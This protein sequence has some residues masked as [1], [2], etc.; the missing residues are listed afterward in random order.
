[1]QHHDSTIQCKAGYLFVFCQTLEM[2]LKDRNL[3]IL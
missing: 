1:M 2:S 3:F